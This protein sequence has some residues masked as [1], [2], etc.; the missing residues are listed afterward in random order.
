MSTLGSLCS[1]CLFVRGL[2]HDMLTSRKHTRFPRC[3]DLI[4]SE[5]GYGPPFAILMA[6]GP[7]VSKGNTNRI[8]FR[9]RQ[10]V[11]RDG[12]SVRAA[13]W[14]FLISLQIDL[15]YFSSQWSK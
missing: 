10:H 4:P 13:G 3:S 6:V 5:F 7:G 14:R 8:S 1:F 15:H 12:S 9:Y 11:T 2:L